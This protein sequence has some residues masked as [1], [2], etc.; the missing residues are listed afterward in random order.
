[1]P[2]TGHVPVGYFGDAAQIGPA[3]VF[4]ASDAS[5]YLNGEVFPIDGGV[6]AGGIS[7]TGYAP[8]MPWAA[9]ATGGL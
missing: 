2:N 9:D 7:P 8:L 6:A 5:E 1:M 4:L 3:V